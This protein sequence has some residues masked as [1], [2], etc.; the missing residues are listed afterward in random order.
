MLY[1]VQN[2]IRNTFDLSGI[3][4]F[5][6]DPDEVGEQ[7]GWQNGLSSARQLPTHPV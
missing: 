5:R 4:D 6:T 7:E 3:W 2:D 1:P